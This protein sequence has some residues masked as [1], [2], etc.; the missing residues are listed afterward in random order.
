[1]L[2]KHILSRFVFAITLF[3]A[4]SVQAAGQTSTVVASG[5]IVDEEGQPV[6]GAAVFNPD[7]PSSGTVTDANGTFSFK[8]G[9]GT[10]LV[11]SSI[12][13]EDVSFTAGQNLQI[14]MKTSATMLD[15]T[16]VVGYGVQRRESVVGAVS[17]IENKTIVNSGLSNVTQAIAGKLSGVVTL[18][19]SGA[20]GGDDATIIVRGVSSWNGSAPLV[21][22]DGVERSFNTLDPNEIATISVLKDASATAVFGAKGANG[23]ILVTTR[24]GQKG[25]PK[26]NVSVSQTLKMPTML[27]EH[28]DAYATVSALNVAYKNS[29]SWSQLVSDHDLQ[30]FKHPSSALNAIRYPDNNWYDLLLKDVAN[31]TDANLNL[32]GGTDRTKYFISLGYKHDGSIFKKQRFDKTNFD[33]QRLNYRA[34]LDFN[35]TE[36]TTISYRVG[37][38]IGIRNTPGDSPISS[39]FSS[40]GVS[41]P[42][43]YP[44][45]VLEQVPDWD[46]PNASGDR[47]VTPKQSAWST[48]Y[49]NPYNSLNIPS[50]T[51]NTSVKLFTDLLFKQSLDMLTQG[52]S[53]SGKFSFS[54]DMSRVSESVSRSLPTYYLNWDYLDAGQVN[55]W[56]SSVSGTNVVEDTPYA[57]T[58]GD[59]SSHSYSLYW[60]ASINYDRTWNNHHVTAMS[61]VN[62]RENKSN[63]SFPYRSMGIVGRMTYDYAHKYLLE[64]N[65]GY[66][67]SEQFAPA[68]RF[69]LFP[70]LALGY[71]LSNEKWWK[72]AMPWWSKMKLRFSDGFVGSD[73]AGGQ[74]WLYF[75]SYSK[76][77]DGYI[78]Q[79]AA[80][81]ES[82]QWEMAQKRDLGIEMGWFKNRLTAELDLF[83]EHRTNILVTPVI[84]MLVGTAYKQ[85]NKGEMK[86]HGFEFEVKW[87]DKFSNG[88]G[89][90]LSAM[91]SFNENRIINYEDPPYLP[92]YQK[93]AGKPF[94]GQQNGVSVIDSGYYTSVDD[95]HNYPSYAADWSYVPIGAYKYLD[96]NADG[97]LNANDLH[98]VYGSQYPS[99][100]GSVGFGLN[101]KGWEFSA[102]FYG[103]FGKYANYNAN[104]ELDFVKGDVRLSESMAD[105]WSP[106]NPD[107]NHATLVYNGSAGHPMYS[108]AG[109]TAGQTA[110]MGLVGRTWRKVDYVNLRDVY[111]A[112]TFDKNALKSKAGVNSLT[113]YL[114]GNNLLYFTDL[115]S[116]NP[117]LTSF[118]T[119]AYPLMRTVQFGLKVGF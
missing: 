59:I 74:R 96:Y 33:Y 56:I 48:Y 61:L 12:G 79:D 4:L 14:R 85:V 53:V 32:S 3:L 1:M 71:V 52:L 108:W 9:K 20:P 42:A 64:F 34:N 95:V 6:V 106:T 41:F 25:K 69:G 21:M 93:V 117:E 57:A 43:Y 84:P 37:G 58:Q 44:A 23:V 91:V 86:K 62:Q 81:N 94:A 114:T 83:D 35:I 16:I 46:Y 24:V 54:T 92:D 45:W 60:E 30:E 5:V 118:T 104:Y 63:Y 73:S 98:S 90:Y 66:T 82:A 116:G 80:A 68:N 76:N 50:Y 99:A 38:S 70:S 107:A 18:Q 29:Q 19:S 40:S 15:E 75:S 100:L 89:Y 7:N 110:T 28:Q 67:G 49:G 10:T 65:V 112:Y 13:Y 72:K 101:W 36:Y 97:L 22:V 77:S 78:Y 88:L 47:L 31:A 102:L 39:M 11:A 51:E 109:I 115:L 119:G 113:V 55:P 27:P 87:S 17:Q 103:N 8:V 26:L 111:L 105:F 2:T